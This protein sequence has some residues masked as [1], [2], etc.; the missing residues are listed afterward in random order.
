MQ[1]TE[2]SV[3]SLAFHT[4]TTGYPLTIVKSDDNKRAKLH[5]MRYVLHAMPYKGEDTKR[6]GVVD[7]LP[8]GRA[9]V[10][11]EREEHAQ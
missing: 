3:T 11:H 5:A 10:I 9:N 7:D 4:D 1:E 8:V 6:I 2:Y